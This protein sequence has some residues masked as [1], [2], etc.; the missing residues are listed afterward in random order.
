MPRRTYIEETEDPI[1]GEVTL[2]EADTLE[3]LDALA[4]AGTHS[5]RSSVAGASGAVRGD[6]YPVASRLASRDDRV[7]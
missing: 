3:Q 5:L 4:A 6:V 1:T 7:K 2:L